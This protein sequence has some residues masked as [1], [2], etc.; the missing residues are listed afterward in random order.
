MKRNRL[1][2]GGVGIAATVLTSGALADTF[3]SSQ[4]HVYVTINSNVSVAIL[5]ANKQL[6]PIQVGTTTADVGF[7][8]QANQQTLTLGVG[9]TDLY[10]GGDPTNTEVTPLK[11]DESLGAT[12]SPTNANPTDGASNVAR[13]V[14]DITVNGMHG[15]RTND[16]S[17]ESSQNGRFG[18]DVHVHLGWRQTDPVQP[19]GEYSGYVVLYTALLRKHGGTQ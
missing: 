16:I 11:V 14:S 13:F 15:R 8:V 18:Q 1:T 10:K 7:R 4:A 6:S 9:A 5:D 19:L 12:I 17:F 2:L 3:S